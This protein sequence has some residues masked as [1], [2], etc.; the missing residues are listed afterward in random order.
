MY[1]FDPAMFDFK[2]DV[3]KE[4]EKRFKA[5]A[6]LNRKWFC[7]IVS[8]C[9]VLEPAVN[10]LKT[11]FMNLISGYQ[12]HK[13]IGN[14]AQLDN[15]ATICS[16]SLQK[17]QSLCQYCGCEKHTR[18]L[19]PASKDRC[20]YCYK[21]GHFETV[22]RKKLRNST[23]DIDDY[24][25]SNQVATIIPTLSKSMTKIKVNGSHLDALV[26][27][28]SCQSFIRDGIAKQLG[29]K[30][31][32]HKV[33]I[34]MASNS[35]QVDTLGKVFVSLEI[36]GH[37]YNSFCLSVFPDLCADV[38]IG[39]DLLSQ[40][41]NLEISFQGNREKLSLCNDAKATCNVMRAN[42]EPVS[43]FSSLPRDCQPVACRSR[44][45]SEED[46]QFIAKEVTQLLS[47]GTIEPSHS[48][49]RAQVLVVGGTEAH[50]SRLVIDY[51]RTVNKFTELDAYPLPNIE[52]L[53]HKVSQYKVFSMLDLK[54]AYHQI[55]I[56]DHERP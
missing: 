29:L 7:Q 4:T 55:P 2:P 47:D 37:F 23:S 15:C 8:S 49:W 39:H 17:P 53:A 48:P 9:H 46:Q 6:S 51:S 14:N 1:D 45:Y 12:H 20:T 25:S 44:R 33:S 42:I 38:L 19:C 30:T 10:K 54:S 18:N 27:T 35:T 34:N 11:G 28:G 52:A 24:S 32:P 56:I 26:D 16:T 41:S 13:N 40:H 36:Q 22:C 5:F 21:R 43:L 31:Y 3:L 50:R